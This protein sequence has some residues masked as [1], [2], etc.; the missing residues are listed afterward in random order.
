MFDKKNRVKF[1]AL[2]LFT[3]SSLYAS[4][5]L[6]GV[7]LLVDEEPITLYEI[8]ALAKKEHIPVQQAVDI[9]IKKCLKDVETKRLGIDADEFEVSE[10]IQ[11]IAIKN[12]MSSYEL[13]R[14][15]YSKG[16]SEEEYRK[17]IAQT[18]K[19]RKL[20]GRLF[21]DKGAKADQSKVINNYFDKLKAKANIEIIRKP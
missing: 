17:N 11:S 12:N 14:L 10:E 6:N 5:L 7:S 9:L 4:S 1:L 16:M 2:A 18:I 8:H 19:D 21:Q 20:F 3:G 13:I 15:V